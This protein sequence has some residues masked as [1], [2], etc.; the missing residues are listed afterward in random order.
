MID[1][2]SPAERA[3][4]NDPSKAPKKKQVVVPVFMT[5]LVKK[6]AADRGEDDSVSLVGTL[7]QRPLLYDL[8]ALRRGAGTESRPYFTM[9]VNEGETD[10]S[11]CFEQGSNTVRRWP[12][13][14]APSSV[15]FHSLR[16]SFRR[17]IISRSDLERD[18]LSLERAR[19]EQPR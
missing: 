9:R 2:R 14:K 3:A 11:D 10:S 1:T 17:A 7:I 18:R 19:A 6:L 15:G 8:M 4:R 16:L 12:T 13:S 5:I